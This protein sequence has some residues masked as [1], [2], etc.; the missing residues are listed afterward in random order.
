MAFI[1]DTVQAL[2]DV[3][4]GGPA[5]WRERLGKEIILT[6]P[7]GNEF[8]A[9]WRGGERTLPKKLGILKF[10]K[11]KGDIIQDMDVSSMMYPI[12]FF[13]EG[14]NN[15]IEAK[16]FIQS[17]SETGTWT[18]IHPVYGFLGLQL[19]TVSDQARPVE[20]GNIT[21]IN[22][23]WFEPLDPLTLKTARQLAGIIDARIDD[24]NINAAQQF[25]NNLVTISE[26]LRGSIEATTTGIQRVTDFTLG[27]LFTTVDALDNAVNA[28]QRGI[29]D[30][31][32][33]TVLPVNSLA[34]QV[35]NL[36][37]L[38]LFANN[39]LETRLTAYG[40]VISG[41]SNQLPGGSESLMP[42]TA[43]EQV[44]INS[45]ATLELGLSAALSAV[46]QITTTSAVS[47]RGLGPDDTG[48]LATKA[49]A[50]KA[51]EDL[52]AAFNAV[53]DNLDAAQE[54]FSTNDVDEQYY[55]QSESFNDAAILI[56]LC[57]EYLLSIAFEL[58]VERRFVID[59]PRAPIEITITE[60]GTLGE[61]DSN[62]DLFIRANELVGKDILL[63]PRGREVV[64]YV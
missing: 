6:S 37:T 5:N 64:V 57:I 22:S 30:T 14:E 41:L 56:S 61:N 32:N 54:L 44:K 17:C 12:T 26:T 53:I 20:S 29:T 13:F 43:S 60:Y 40:Q 11:I 50:I 33:A 1:S 62:L 49:Q 38:P 10:P 51:V 7:E 46:A 3:F 28:I 27:P 47:P 18:V 36:I 59:K 4:L 63:L 35:Q 52:T 55:S 9:K 31:H 16:A 24:L 48:A 21:E 39:Q 25:A 15:D 58:S 23:Q 19:A 34:G 8:R 2:V 45:V 42:D